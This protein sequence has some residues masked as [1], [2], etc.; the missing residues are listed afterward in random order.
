MGTMAVISLSRAGLPIDRQAI[1]DRGIA[2]TNSISLISSLP[3]V[4]AATAI[5]T[6]RVRVPSFSSFSASCAWAGPG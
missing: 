6:P 2:V 4:R 3:S 1:G 5:S